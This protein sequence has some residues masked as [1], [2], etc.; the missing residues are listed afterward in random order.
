MQNT[1]TQISSDTP[2]NPREKIDEIILLLREIR[3]TVHPPLWRRSVKFGFAHIW[4]ILAFVMLL[5][6]SFYVWQLFGIVQSINDRIDNGQQRI[7]TIKDAA[8]EKIESWKFWK[9]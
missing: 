5:F 1:T 6:L 8:Q 2:G 4:Q 9:K 3:D 7:E